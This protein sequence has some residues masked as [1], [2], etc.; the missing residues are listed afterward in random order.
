V[1]RLGTDP[2]STRKVLCGIEPKFTRDPERVK[3]ATSL[4]AELRVSLRRSFRC[5]CSA[6]YVSPHRITGSVLEEDA[7]EQELSAC[8]E[9]TGSRPDGCP[10][11]VLSDPWVSEVVRAHK[12]FKEHQ[13]E[14]RYGGAPPSS[15]VWG[16]EVYDA[17][18]NSVQVHDFREDSEER[19][20]QAREREQRR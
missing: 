10:W 16:V 20:K 13:L 2:G 9:L 17:A 19:E 1:A 12:W 8:E 7:G 15:I 3:L 4:P 11:R 14:T 5:P 6:E 18:L